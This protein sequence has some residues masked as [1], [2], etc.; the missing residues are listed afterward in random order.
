[1]AENK[2]I[3]Q[4]GFGEKGDSSGNANSPVTKYRALLEDKVFPQ[5]E[6][7]LRQKQQRQINSEELGI[8]YEKIRTG[9][10]EL[11]KDL[12]FLEKQY[13]S[14]TPFY[15]RLF[16]RL[17]KLLAEAKENNATLLKFRIKNL[18]YEIV[19][20]YKKS[21]YNV[22]NFHHLFRALT[23]IIHKLPD[24]VFSEPAV[25]IIQEKIKSE[26]A[27]WIGDGFSGKSPMHKY[28]AVENEDTHFLIPFKRK[29]WEK[30]VENKS[31]LKIQIKSIPGDNIFLFKRLP[32]NASNAPS[33]KMAVL[34]ETEDNEKNG[35]LTDKIDGIMIFS[36]KF[37]KK[38]M[39]YFPVGDSTFSPYLTLKGIR[40]FIRQ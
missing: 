8:F 13:F 39:D 24:E 10:G 36:E 30:Q 6:G 37:L 35:I 4:D 38:N 40:Y 33:Q 5:K 3:D 21:G 32:G 18:N 29:L 15:E 7:L 27:K 23:T 16:N 11:E 26:A 20:F 25:K 34:M 9:L 12:L 19:R 31:R 17:E 1:M 14:L 28:L 2:N 22:E